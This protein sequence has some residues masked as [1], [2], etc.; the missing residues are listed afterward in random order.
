MQILSNGAV[1]GGVGVYWMFYSGGSF[2]P[3]EIPAGFPE[4]PAGETL[5]GLR[6]VLNC[7]VRLFIFYINF[8]N[9]A[10]KV[11]SSLSDRIY[12]NLDHVSA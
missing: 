12:G 8:I 9:S 5:E 11:L 10:V 3:I 7:N 4:L 1:R 6:Q 2:E